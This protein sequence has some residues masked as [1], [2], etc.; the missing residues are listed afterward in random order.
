M[1]CIIPFSF[2][3]FS[4]REWTDGTSRVINFN[5]L[6]LRAECVLIGIFDLALLV[7][8]Y[9]SPIAP[10]INLMSAIIWIIFPAVL[11]I[12]GASLK[13]LHFMWPW[14]MN[15][16]AVGYF[17]VFFLIE[18][19]IGSGKFSM[20]IN[21]TSATNDS[22]STDDDIP[23]VHLGLGVWTVV[24]VLIFLFSRLETVVQFMKDL[25]EKSIRQQDQHAS[26]D[27]QTV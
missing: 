20:N 19:S 9:L 18:C 8:L 3:K 6:S 2:V 25:Y 16:F 13:Y 26:I 24:F 21:I 12:V 23:H 1:W 22:R 14:I 27:S 11:L 10:Y 15:N 7:F 5:W 4:L 17:I